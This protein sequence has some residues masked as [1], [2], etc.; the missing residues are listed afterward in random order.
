MI[1]HLSTG[2]QNL[3]IVLGF[4]CHHKKAAG[5]EPNL[6]YKQQYVFLYDSQHVTKQTEGMGSFSQLN[7]HVDLQ[8]QRLGSYVLVELVW[9]K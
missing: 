9:G 3:C 7:T 1:P 6:T 4:H 2:N 5:Q 8:A